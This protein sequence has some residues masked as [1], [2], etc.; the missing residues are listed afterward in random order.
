[1]DYDVCSRISCLD[2]VFNWIYCI[3]NRYKRIR[4][5]HFFILIYLFISFLHGR[6]YE[7]D[8]VLLGTDSFIYIYYFNKEVDI[9][10]YRIIFS[11]VS[12]LN[13]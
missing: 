3:F 4:H 7:V 6:I 8:N 1:M 12:F 9:S 10:F 11:S 5:Y 13:C 2:N